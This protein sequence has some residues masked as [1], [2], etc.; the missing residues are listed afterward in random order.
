VLMLVLRECVVGGAVLRYVNTFLSK[1]AGPKG[2]MYRHAA[3]NGCAAVLAQPGALSV[4]HRSHTSAN[5][6]G[7]LTARRA[8]RA[9]TW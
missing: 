6:R 3:A 5:H 8:T 4:L 9:G 7:K 1:D 2:A